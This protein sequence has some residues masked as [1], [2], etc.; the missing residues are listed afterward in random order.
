M[1]WKIGFCPK[2]MFD[3]IWLPL[4]IIAGLSTCSKLQQTEPK[5]IVSS[6][7]QDTV[8]SESE[9]SYENIHLTELKA[10]PVLNIK[11]LPAKVPNFTPDGWEVYDKV[12]KFTAESLYELINGGAELYLA[13]DMVR[14]IYVNFVSKANS[15]L[16]IKLFIYDMS[17][18]TNAF[19]IFSIERFQGA[20]SLNLGRDSYNVDAHYFIWKGQY[21][22]RVIASDSTKELKQIGMNI[23]R[24]VTS[25]LAD[26][27]DPVW[28]LTGL[29]QSDLV[30]DSVKYFQVDAMG[31]DFMR[32]IYTAKYLKGSTQITAFLSRQDSSESA[33]DTVTRYLEHTQKYG[34]GIEHLTQNGVDFILCNMGGNFDIIFQKGR[35]VGGVISV[36]DRTIATQA[37]VDFWKQ[38]HYE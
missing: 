3:W 9:G 33:Q 35:L 28:G 19:G 6:Q 26:S 20:P 16:F 17:T 38:L 37:A 2:Q 14:M 4:I 11:S 15:R 29:P 18:P 31:L 23:V 32:N 12:R 34:E 30:P 7:K 5:V 21:Y 25:F 10:N 36:A 22:I 27:G 24:K 8:H 13:Y 1:I